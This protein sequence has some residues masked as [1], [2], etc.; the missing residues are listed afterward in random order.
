MHVASLHPIIVPLQLLRYLLHLASSF[1]SLIHRIPQSQH[2]SHLGIPYEIV[3]VLAIHAIGFSYGRLLGAAPAATTRS[4]VIG[5]PIQRLTER[6]QEVLGLLAEGM[7]NHEIAEQLSIS[8]N[9]L[10]THLRRIYRKVKARNRI[11]AALWYV[12]WIPGEGSQR[13]PA[14]EVQAPLA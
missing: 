14:V 7:R 10:E 12:G 2:A 3:L 4:R 8:E 5:Q 11:E 1:G 6:E 13:S 9:T